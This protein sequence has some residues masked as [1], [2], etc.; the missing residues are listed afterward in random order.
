[1]W[2]Y[3]KSELV[4]VSLWTTASDLVSCFSTC[5]GSEVVN[6][7]HPMTCNNVCVYLASLPFSVTPPNL[8]GGGFS[9]PSLCLLVKL[10]LG[11]TN[12]SATG[13]IVWSMYELWLLQT[14]ALVLINMTGMAVCYLFPSLTECVAVRGSGVIGWWICF[15]GCH[16][17][18]RVCMEDHLHAL[19]SISP[20]TD[21][22]EVCLSVM[23][24]CT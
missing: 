22:C 15:L 5:F 6:T 9:T 2:R 14:E 8:R 16:S 3:L 11:L 17:N 4:N 10:C 23:Y 1:M 21:C 12:V 24:C 20:H 13:V 18:Q 19:S 7:N